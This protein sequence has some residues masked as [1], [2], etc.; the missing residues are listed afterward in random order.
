MDSEPLA[1]LE[2]LPIFP[3]A[4][5]LFPGA[6]L[7]LHIFEER[8]KQLMQYAIENGGVFGL[9]YRKDAEVGRETPP[10]IGSVGCVAKI[11]AVM[12]LEEGRLNL[13][14]T[15]VIRYRVTGLVQLV[16]FL[17][18]RIETFHDFPELDEDLPRLFEEVAGVCKKFFEAADP[19]ATVSPD[20]PD[21]P[22][23]FSLL[24]ASAFPVDN[25]T[26]QGL[27]EMTS[28]RGRLMRLRRYVTLALEQYRERM[29]VQQRARGNG[30]GKLK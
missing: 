4:T 19:N 27:L 16:P 7:P 9:S 28:T 2:E 3:L 5:V 1:G 26:K 25:D 24:I 8:Y 17:I 23:T 18:A 30:H 15:G 14:S 13:I 11:G 21:D 29:K 6:V 12:P 22:E 10:D 20:L